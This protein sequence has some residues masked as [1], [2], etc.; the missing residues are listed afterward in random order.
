MARE[1]YYVEFIDGKEMFWFS[2]YRDAFHSS[3]ITEH[4]HIFSGH[5]RMI[6]EIM[7]WEESFGFIPWNAVAKLYDRL[8]LDDYS[9]ADDI[10]NDYLTI[11]EGKDGKNY[12]WYLDENKEGA[13]RLDDLKFILADET[14]EL[15][16]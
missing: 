9:A 11:N 10:K 15:F 6:S 16:C 4:S 1:V 8:D 13:I 14:K 7:L 2:N 12:L 3:C 5:P